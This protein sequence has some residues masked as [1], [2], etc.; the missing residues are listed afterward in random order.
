MASWYFEME[1]ALN[2]MG[3]PDWHDEVEYGNTRD[4]EVNRWRWEFL[5]RRDDYRN[6]FE[7][8]LK[9]L[10]VAPPPPVDL[11]SGDRT[12][13][14]TLRLFAGLRSWPFEH[15]VAVEYGLS[16]FYD[17]FQS[18]WD[19]IGPEWT[20]GL[21][22]GAVDWD[23]ERLCSVTFDLSKP[24]KRQVSEAVEY[25]EETQCHWLL[26]GSGREEEYPIGGEIEYLQVAEKAVRAPKHHPEKWL[27]YLR[28]LDARADGASLR[29]MALLLPESMGRRDARAAGNVLEQAKAQAFR[30]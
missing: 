13:E 4:W 3:I 11:L 20:S 21:S 16:H 8:A 9:S 26:Y 7:R 29:D 1:G 17:P 28:L 25:L 18:N 2:E 6:A 23:D 27:T 14:T 19:G 24:L 15:A 12:D 10:K 5:R 22:F 30:F